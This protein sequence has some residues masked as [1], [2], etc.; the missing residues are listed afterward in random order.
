[1]FIK[2]DQYNKDSLQLIIESLGLEKKEAIYKAN[3]KA[4]DIIGML[5]SK[6]LEMKLC[7]DD[8]IEQIKDEFMENIAEIFK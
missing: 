4:E 5:R 7:D 1:L 2:L 3:N 8:Q 6:C